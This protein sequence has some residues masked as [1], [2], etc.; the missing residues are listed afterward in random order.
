MKTYD[1]Y[2]YSYDSDLDVARQAVES[3]LNIQMN[4]HESLYHCGD[5]YRLGKDGAENFILQLNHDDFEDEWT[6]EEHKDYPLVLYV[7][8]TSRAED[9]ER[10]LTEKF[11]LLRREE[12]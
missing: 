3:L 4:K 1:L 11:K 9:I 8:E 12:L 10:K 2:G 7:N 5:Y 6:E